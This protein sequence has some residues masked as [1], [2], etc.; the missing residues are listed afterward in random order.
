M[1]A[2]SIEEIKIS[3]RFPLIDRKREVPKRIMVLAK[4]VTIVT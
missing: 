1:M 2:S 3:V 4:T